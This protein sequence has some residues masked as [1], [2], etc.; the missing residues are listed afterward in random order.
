MT[1]NPPHNLTGIDAVLYSQ[2]TDPTSAHTVPI[3]HIFDLEQVTWTSTHGPRT[4]DEAD[5]ILNT[6]HLLA[7]LTELWQDRPPSAATAAVF[8]ATE[9]GAGLLA[10]TGYAPSSGESARG[11]HGGRLGEGLASDKE[12]SEVDLVAFH[13][14]IA[15]Y[16]ETTSLETTSGVS[17]SGPSTTSATTQTHWVYRAPAASTHPKMELKILHKAHAHTGHPTLFIQL[18][19]VQ[20]L[21][22]TGHESWTLTHTHTTEGGTTTSQDTQTIGKYTSKLTWA[23]PTPHPPDQTTTT[24]TLAPHDTQSAPE[25]SG[26]RLPED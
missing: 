26:E 13:L 5:H 15:F 2:L 22:A 10:A 4:P 12:D 11:E 18:D 21:A 14:E 9:E 1:A 7:L 20:A 24:I 25:S 3:T 16:L 19:D 17:R 23:I 8:Q 6:P